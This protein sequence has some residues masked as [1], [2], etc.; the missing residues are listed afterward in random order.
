MLQ[1]LIEVVRRVGDNTV[2]PRYLKVARQQKD[3][4]SVLTEADLAA[5]EMLQQE[6]KLVFDCPLVGEEMLAEEQ[7][8][9]WDAG[10]DGLW[11]VDPLDGTSNFASG[12]PYFGISVAFLQDGKPRMG[13]VYAPCLLYTSPSPRD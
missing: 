7:R 9:N 11:C 10:A 8:R 1:K 5:Q 2:L 6:L 12:L 4:G 13:V 3:D